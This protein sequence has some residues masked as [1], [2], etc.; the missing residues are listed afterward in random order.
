MLEAAQ[1]R[2]PS[3][4][5]NSELGRREIEKPVFKLEPQSKH[6][7]LFVISEAKLNHGLLHQLTG[8]MRW[9]GSY[10]SVK[11]P[12]CSQVLRKPLNRADVLVKQTVQI[13][14]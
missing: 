4:P 6:K 3:C 11:N 5:L 13:S 7:H 9:R 10:N 8:Q 12:V 2:D 1:G 14:L